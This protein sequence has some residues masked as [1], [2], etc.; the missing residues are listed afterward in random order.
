M[1]LI[2]ILNS[3]SPKLFQKFLTHEEKSVPE[4]VSYCV[5]LEVI[6][7]VIIELI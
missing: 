3:F 7:V 2:A 6:T 5:I 4:H 1:T